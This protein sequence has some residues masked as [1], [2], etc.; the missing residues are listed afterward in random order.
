MYTNNLQSIEKQVNKIVCH[1]ISKRN[2]QSNIARLTKINRSD[3][4][5]RGW[6][7]ATL[8]LIIK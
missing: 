2:C 7:G 1:D 3:K 8:V 4:F 5:C 6:E